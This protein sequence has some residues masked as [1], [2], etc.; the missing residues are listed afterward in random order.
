MLFSQ[1]YWVSL[2]KIIQRPG[3]LA[4]WRG[5]PTAPSQTAKQEE[6]M[7]LSSLSL[8]ILG[9]AFRFLC[10]SA[11]AGSI[12]WEAEDAVVINLPLAVFEDADPNIVSGHGRYI[13]SPASYAGSA[14][15]DFDVPMN[16]TFFMWAHHLSIDSSRNSY[17][18]V[19]DDPKQPTDES[20]AWDTILQPQPKKLG[21]VVNINNKD[22]Y[23]NEWGWIRVFGR[24]DAQWMLY[25]IRTFELKKGSH[26]MYLWV[27]ER[28]TK[29]DCFC[30]TDN[31]DEQPVFPDEA[32]GLGV[33]PKEKLAVV[34]GALK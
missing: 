18:L 33:D 10:S 12:G 16:G 15:Y 14:E 6:V 28:E 3:A 1:D 34:W 11:F 25:L 31:F 17:Y 29:V 9:L 7:K 13:Y 21:E 30:L 8:V 22:V 19:I 27:R 4:K 2:E 20:L 23:S 32:K 26:K 24:Q 5:S